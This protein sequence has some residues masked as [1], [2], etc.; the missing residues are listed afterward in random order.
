LGELIYFSTPGI[1]EKEIDISKQVDGIYYLKVI[2]KEGVLS[3]E[4]IKSGR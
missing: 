4:I 2:T 3:G 1:Q